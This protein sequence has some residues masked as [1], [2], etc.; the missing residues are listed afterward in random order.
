MREVNPYQGA[1]VYAARADGSVVIDRPYAYNAYKQ[2]DSP[3]WLD[4][5]RKAREGGERHEST[6][7]DFLRSAGV[8]QHQ[9]CR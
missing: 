7:S 9:R 2:G 8:L 5:M 3:V 1:L 6:K 4:M